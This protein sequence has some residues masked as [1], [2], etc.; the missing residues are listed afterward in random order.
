MNTNRNAAAESFSTTAMQIAR[1]LMSD[2]GCTAER[3]IEVASKWLM[4]KMVA[5]NPT[6]ALKVLA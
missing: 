2:T 4:T 3:A 6:L 5:E 1:N